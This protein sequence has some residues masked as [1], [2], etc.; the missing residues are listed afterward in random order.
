MDD[1]DD[2]DVVGCDP[3]VSR[4]RALDNTHHVPNRQRLL[5]SLRMATHPTYQLSSTAFQLHV[6]PRIPS[7]FGGPT[8]VVFRPFRF[9]RLSD[10][11]WRPPFWAR[12]PCTWYP[13]YLEVYA[14]LV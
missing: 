6:R 5:F 3:F 2:M 4:P 10:L 1:M 14:Q 9:R 8:A 13:T 11:A 12:K 7:P